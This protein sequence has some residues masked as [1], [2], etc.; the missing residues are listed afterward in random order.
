MKKE[1]SKDSKDSKFKSYIIKL[2]DM[3]DKFFTRVIGDGMARGIYSIFTICII[4]QTC[5]M[6]YL[7]L[8]FEPD[9]TDRGDLKSGMTMYTDYGTGCQYLKSGFFAAPT[10]RMGP[11]GNQICLTERE[12]NEYPR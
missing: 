3:D 7:K 11:D 9:V 6:I 8:T 5:A 10:P 12:L 2:P 4:I 1:D